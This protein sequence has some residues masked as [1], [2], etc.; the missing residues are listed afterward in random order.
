MRKSGKERLFSSLLFLLYRDSAAKQAGEDLR[1]SFGNNC[2]LFHT[3]VRM[4]SSTSSTKVAGKTS[5]ELPSY[6]F[7]SSWLFG[8]AGDFWTTVQRQRY[9]RSLRFASEAMNVFTST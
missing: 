3:F 4:V 1:L 5:T 9:P 8:F 7:L 2:S 6:D